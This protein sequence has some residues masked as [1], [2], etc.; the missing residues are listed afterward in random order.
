MLF[1]AIIGCHAVSEQNR[2]SLQCNYAPLGC[3][4]V[5]IPNSYALVVSSGID[6]PPNNLQAP[7]LRHLDSKK[8]NGELERWNG[9]DY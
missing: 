7:S 2:K 6:K 1:I 4:N 9:M 3:K 5:I 8:W